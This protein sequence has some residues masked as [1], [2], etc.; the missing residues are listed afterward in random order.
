[1]HFNIELR[2]AGGDARSRRFVLRGATLKIN[3]VYRKRGEDT[4]IKFICGSKGFIASFRHA[5]KAPTISA[6]SDTST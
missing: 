4:Y 5:V 6:G 1:M 3:S 2:G